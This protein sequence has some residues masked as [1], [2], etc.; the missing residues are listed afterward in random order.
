MRKRRHWQVINSRIVYQNPRMTVKEY[1]VIKPGGQKGVYSVLEKPDSCFIIPLT[2]KGTIFLIEESRFPIKKTILQLPAGLIEDKK[3]LESARNE[4]FQETG[5][6]ANELK[7]IGQ[8]YIGAGHQTT[9]VTVVLASQLD[10][11]QIGLGQQEGD[12]AIMGIKE[13]KIK[14]LKKMIQ[15]NK[16][17]CGISLAA[18][19]L[20]FN[21]S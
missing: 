8:F 1:R 14:D 11:S 21:Q 2:K 17:E 10:L 15:E 7:K 16:I 12:E 3:I 4:L 19:N 13:V 20:F 5:I 18:L 9:K 6:Q